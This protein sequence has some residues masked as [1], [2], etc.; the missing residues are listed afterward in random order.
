MKRKTLPTSFYQFFNDLEKKELEPVKTKSFTLP[1]LYHESKNGKISELIISVEMIDLIP[2]VITCW[3]YV[4]G[5]KQTTAVKVSK[6]KNL[7]RSNS[8]TA[9]EQ[10]IANATSKWNN[11]KL[12]NYREDLNEPDKSLPMKAHNY[13]DHKNKLTWP[14]YAQPKLNGVRCFANR[15]KNQVEY[16]SRKSKEYKT[17]NH[18]DNE[19]LRIFKEETLVDGEAYNKD[20]N[21]QQIIRRCKRV[22]SS[23]ADIDDVTLQ[24]WI[25]D[26]VLKDTP[27]KDRYEFLSN[28][29]VDEYQHLKLV[30]T[31]LICN[32]TD[33]KLYHKENIAKGYEGTMVRT[34]QGLYIC[35][36]RSYDLLKLKDFIDKEFIIIGGEQAQGKDEGTVIF[37]CVNPINEE[38]FKVR[39][40][41]TFA[42]RKW[43][44]DNLKQ[45]IGKE[46]TVRYYEHSEKGTP[47]HGVGLAIRDYE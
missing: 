43:Y 24:Y 35:G 11:K 38:V 8:T 9:W 3:G 27:F 30:E 22:L 34:P 5:A 44:F 28:L 25:Y 39:P 46:L 33:L 14:I 12:E 18:W 4:G 19:I 26:V 2:N 17:F 47:I 40:K 21:F 42:R 23:R 31:R 36:Y 16:T 37:R 32:E 41:G 10:A 13:K 29:L 15:L 45:F 7:G 6:G 1:P 20:L